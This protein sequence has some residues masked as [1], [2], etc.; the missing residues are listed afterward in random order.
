VTPHGVGIGW[1]IFTW[2]VCVTTA[3]EAKYWQVHEQ[4]LKVVADRA[5][6]ER[7]AK[8]ATADTKVDWRE[9]PG[10]PKRS[11]A[12]IYPPLEVMIIQMRRVYAT[13]L[14]FM[15]ANELGARTAATAGNAASVQSRLDKASIV[16]AIE[17]S[18]RMSSSGILRT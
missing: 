8:R 16:S 15:G 1:V 14:E 18:S 13:M 2:E 5:E 3:L 12:F 9:P 17:R 10:S 7:L 6:F 4:T 11:L